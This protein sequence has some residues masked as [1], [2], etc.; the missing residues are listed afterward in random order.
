MGVREK[1][2]S[3]VVG[4]YLG[5]RREEEQLCWLAVGH[6]LEFNAYKISHE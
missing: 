3:D 4:I 2:E 6:L 5:G 1:E